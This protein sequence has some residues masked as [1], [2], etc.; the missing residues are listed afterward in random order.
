MEQ[1]KKRLKFNREISSE[2]FSTFDSRGIANSTG[3]P[4]PIHE[5]E[6]SSNLNHLT[7][8]VVLLR[9]TDITK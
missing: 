9:N 7:K 5:L 8:V 1:L 2:H 3:G 6:L 4:H